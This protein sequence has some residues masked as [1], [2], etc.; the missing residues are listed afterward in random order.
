MG[1]T[2]V[3]KGNKFIPCIENGTGDILSTVMW[4]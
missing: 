3:I 1:I 4:W 2:T